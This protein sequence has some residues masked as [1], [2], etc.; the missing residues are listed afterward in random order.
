MSLMIREATVED[1]P[2]IYKLWDDLMEL[3][4]AWDSDFNRGPNAE[5][6]YSDLLIRNINNKVGGL[7]L[8]AADGPDIVGFCMAQHNAT[9]RLFQVTHYGEIVDFY[10]SPEY[11]RHGLGTAL[12]KTAEEWFKKQNITYMELKAYL[13]N[14]MSNPFW[15]KMGYNPTMYV[16]NK[17]G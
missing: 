5:Q 11:R 15:R 7:V 2:A 6:I 3:H 9:I 17:K 14:G 13:Y 8:V 4:A 10:I 16:M 1:V 12:Y